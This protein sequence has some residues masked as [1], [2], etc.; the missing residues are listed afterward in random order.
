MKCYFNKTKFNNNLELLQGFYNTYMKSGT[1]NVNNDTAGTAALDNN[2]EYNL[3]MQDYSVGIA[4]EDGYSCPS[5]SLYPYTGVTPDTCSRFVSIGDE[6][7][8]VRSWQNGVLVPNTVSPSI[9]SYTDEAKTEYCNANIDAPECACLNRSIVDPSYNQ[10]QTFTPAS[11]YCWYIPCQDST[12]YLITSDLITTCDATV[13][14]SIT[15]NIAQTGGSITDAQKQNISCSSDSTQDTSNTGL[16]GLGIFGG[17]NSSNQDIN[18]ILIIIIVILVIVFVV[19][20]V[21]LI[22]MFVSGSKSKK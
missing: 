1:A 11:P 6:G 5:Y 3:M 15:A 13:C 16:F 22:Y 8:W 18:I 2:S 4:T 9:S 17:S 10:L 20:L 7:D 21:L 14:N 19:G 12:R